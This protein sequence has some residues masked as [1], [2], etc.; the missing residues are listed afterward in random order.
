VSTGDVASQHAADRP[1]QRLR[2]LFWPDHVAVVGA[3]VNNRYARIAVER[4]RRA[5]Y[6]GMVSLVNRSGGEIDG[7]RAVPRMTDLAGRPDFA[8]IAVN[9]DAAVESVL[10]C[11]RL[12][13]PAA[14]VVASGFAETG[15]AAGR[16]RQGTLRA[17][18]RR[19][20]LLICGPTCLGVMNTQARFQA[21]GG[22]L[23]AE[24]PTGGISIVSQSGVFAGVAVTLGPE[25]GVGFSHVISCG[26][27]ATV[28]VCDFIDYLVDD[29]STR[30]I[31][32]FIEQIR[33][34]VEFERVA[35]RALDAGKPLIVAKS[36]RSEGAARIAVAHTGA[37]TGPD[38]YWDA[39]FDGLG[40]IR[41]TTPEETIARAAY[42]AQVS[43]WR[44]PR[45]ARLGILSRSGGMAGIA[46]DVCTQLGMSAPELIDE[47]TGLVIPNPVELTNH[48][49]IH[50]AAA[51]GETL[52]SM[53]GHPAVDC[54]VIVE[55]VTQDAAR[56]ETMADVRERTGTPLILVAAAGSLDCLDDSARGAIAALEVP[57]VAGIANAAL[58]VESAIRYAA[59]RPELVRAPMGP[60]SRRRVPEPPGSG[61]LSERAAR[62]VLAEIGV[63]GPVGDLVA[64]ADEAA[65]A[66]SARPGPFVLKVASPDL[67][68]KSDHALVELGLTSPDEVRAAGQR[69]MSRC[70]A[71]NPAPRLEGL[72]L[73]DMISGVGEVHLG[74]DCLLGELPLV[75]VG[76]GGVLVELLPAA[77]IHAGVLT[78]DAAQ[79]RLEASPIG[80]VLGGYRGAAAVP[81]GPLATLISSVSEYAYEARD[82]LAEFELNPLI[83]LRDGTVRAVDV[84][85][86][87]RSA[88]ARADQDGSP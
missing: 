77:L 31:C 2:P 12:G 82:W 23:G 81:L 68:H 37:T 60:P 43:P 21:Y 78:A 27:E 14:V 86:V 50:D 53:A 79:A 66:A 54:M 3:S 64:G 76:L 57:Y 4:L 39:L 72:L 61:V 32:A 69:L 1:G 70:S 65:R 84:L 44:L 35:R 73:Q 71:I 55:T 74:V 7:R 56:I 40:I 19:S 49:Q 63:H 88:E 59:R 87:K 45:G 42:F 41:A 51:F 25:F 28:D 9:A 17:V 5:G 47:A 33:R 6:A 24:V 52:Q 11:E 80:A 15:E 16:T 58:A 30:V 48:R 85:I 62:Q 10:E 13:V 46:A 20:G 83:V 36:G 18:A 22:R 67:P 75:R 8:F 34:P 26:G 38:E 29:H